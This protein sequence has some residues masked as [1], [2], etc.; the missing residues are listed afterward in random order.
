ML[1]KGESTVVRAFRHLT[2]TI[3]ALAGITILSANCDAKHNV[4]FIV[5][6][7]QG[8]GLSFAGTPAL[9][10]PNMD[11][12]AKEGVCF[13]QAECD[14]ANRDE[15]GSSQVRRNEQSCRPPSRIR[16]EGGEISLLSLPREL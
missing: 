10:T 13:R 2:R 12:I 1:S 3:A 4:L 5:T 16:R 14:G 9:S 8:A 7:D 6:E 11:G 15:Y